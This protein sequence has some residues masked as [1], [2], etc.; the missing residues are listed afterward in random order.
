M[1]P[2][3][4]RA[5]VRRCFYSLDRSFRIIIAIA[6]SATIIITNQ[7]TGINGTS[8]RRVNGARCIAIAYST[9]TGI[10][11]TNQA[12]GINIIRSASVNGARC[13]AMAYRTTRG[14]FTNQATGIIFLRSR[15]INSARCIAIVYTIHI[16]TSQ[17]TGITI[18]IRTSRRRVNRARCIAIV[19]TAFIITS[20]PTSISTI[21]RNVNGARCVAIAYSTT[22]GIFTN[23]TTS[24]TTNITS[25][26]RVNR[27]RC[28]A[29]AYSTTIG[30]C[31][32]QATGRNSTRITSVNGARHSRVLY[33]A[34]TCVAE[35]ADS[36]PLL[37]SLIYKYNH[38]LYFI[39]STIKIASKWIII[40]SNRHPYIVCCAAYRDFELSISVGIGTIVCFFNS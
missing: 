32:N 36:G 22:T 11:F 18:T 2:S 19:Y 35:K 20:Q 24:K 14:S 37:T 15:R 12:T 34:S 23:Q 38:V 6:Y 39:S 33:R 3:K 7:S 31:T 16:T 5:K 10:I 4:P 9:T 21:R 29:I 26:R 17:A 25:R 1:F 27:A 28:I 8:R 30:T 13:I 40:G